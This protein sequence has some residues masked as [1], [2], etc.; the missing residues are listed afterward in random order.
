MRIARFVLDD[1]PQYGLVE[2]EEDQGSHPQTIAVIN[3]D[4]L[5]GPVNYTG[6]RVDLADVR[7]LALS[8]IHI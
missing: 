5:A 2:L 7:L 8:L 6:E 4:P 1:Q 3:R